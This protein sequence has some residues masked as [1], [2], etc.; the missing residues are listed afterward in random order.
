MKSG[1]VS[2]IVLTSPNP[3]LFNWQEFKWWY[4]ISGLLSALFSLRLA[5]RMKVN[6][7]P[8]SNEKI[9]GSRTFATISELKSEF[10]SIPEKAGRFAGGGGFPVSR[11]QSRI[12]IDDSPVNNLIIGTTRSGKTQ[13]AVVPAI[14]IYS[15]AEKQAS[16][17]IADPK[18]ELAASAEATLGQRGYDV[19]IFDLMNFMG[20]S[21]NPLQLV[22]E[23][24]LRGDKAE[25]QLL[26]NTL[27]HILFH[28]PNAKDKTW[29]N[30]SIALTNALILAVTIDCCAEAE[31][32][33][34]EAEKRK[35]YGKINLYSVARLLVD[36]GETDEKGKSSLDRFFLGR[37]LNDIARIQY[38]AVAFAAGK[39]KGNIYANTNSQLIKFTMEKVAKMTSKNTLHLEGIGFSR[40][41][42][43]P[44]SL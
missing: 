22:L 8:L 32:C 25:A 6:F 36:L 34:N 14:D 13:I 42:R 20:L 21:Y 10:R 31:K 33:G 43:L 23:A 1:G 16:M 17:I 41:I 30:W 3:F 28:D 4:L 2:G 5:Y 27:S 7:T 39:T 38:S 44:C 26:A 35:W 40:T 37:G 15:R 9:K 19:R 11:Y 24:Y 18:G 12:F 29:E